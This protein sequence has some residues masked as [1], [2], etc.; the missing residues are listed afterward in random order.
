M[1]LRT[2]DIGVSHG[3]ISK[4]ST[5]YFRKVISN[6]AWGRERFSRWWVCRV[7]VYTTTKRKKK[8]SVIHPS[9]LELVFEASQSLKRSLLTDFF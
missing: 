6:G 9:V 8:G 3:G 5:F 4:G 7:T 1:E 2:T